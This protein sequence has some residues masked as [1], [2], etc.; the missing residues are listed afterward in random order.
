MEDNGYTG[1]GEWIA[2]LLF[3]VQAKKQFLAVK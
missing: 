3:L 2:E 1:G